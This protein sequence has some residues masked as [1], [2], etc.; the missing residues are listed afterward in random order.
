[1]AVL[2]IDRHPSQGR[3]LVHVPSQTVLM[4]Q[5]TA[6]QTW[7]QWAVLTLLTPSAIMRSPDPS[8][9]LHWICGSMQ[10]RNWTGSLLRWAAKAP[11]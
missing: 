6:Y 3:L 11:S 5:G 2:R 7:K 1:M 8:L 10:D 4:G 9:I